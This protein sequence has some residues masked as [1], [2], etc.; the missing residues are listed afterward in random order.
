[1]TQN[2]KSALGKLPSE[3]V[4]FD[5]SRLQILCAEERHD[6][7]DAFQRRFVSILSPRSGRAFADRGGQIVFSSDASFH[8]N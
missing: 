2:D 4:H 3:A 8:W 5:T 1:M 6:T 7:E